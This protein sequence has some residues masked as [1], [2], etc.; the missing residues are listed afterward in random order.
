MRFWPVLGVVVKRAFCIVRNVK[1]ILTVIAPFNTLVCSFTKNQQIMTNSTKSRESLMFGPV[2]CTCNACDRI[3]YTDELTIEDYNANGGY[4]PECF[5]EGNHDNTFP[6]TRLSNAQLGRIYE[7]T[8]GHNPHLENKGV[9]AEVETRDDMLTIL[10]ESKANGRLVLPNLYIIAPLTG[11]QLYEAKAI[12]GETADV[13]AI[14]NERGQH[15]LLMR[16]LDGTLYLYWE[17]LSYTGKNLKDQD[18]AIVLIDCINTL[19][20]NDE[21]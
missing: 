3:I 5:T 16:L 4:C 7:L 21:E 6:L 10:T 9:F 8:I 14:E 20:G 17:N 2:Y 13:V 12:Y 11:D 15:C 18:F 1:Y 19:Y